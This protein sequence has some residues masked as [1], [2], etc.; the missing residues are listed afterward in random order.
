M[1]ALRTCRAP[2]R[3]KAPGQAISNNPTITGLPRAL[4]ELGNLRLFG[5]VPVYFIIAIAVVL[6]AW[7]VLRYTVFGR[8]IYAIGNNEEAVRSRGTTPSP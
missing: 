6:I 1:D 2:G 7:F 5:L 4:T 8:F 3:P